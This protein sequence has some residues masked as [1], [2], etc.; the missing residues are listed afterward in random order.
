MAEPAYPSLEQEGKIGFEGIADQKSGGGGE[1]EGSFSVQFT[2]SAGE[3][4]KQQLNDDPQTSYRTFEGGEPGA[5]QASSED[6]V[7]LEKGTTTQ[8]EKEKRHKEETVL[9]DDDVRRIDFILTYQDDVS[10]KGKKADEDTDEKK[11]KRRAKRKQFLDSCVELGLEYEIQD[12]RET[13]DH[14]TYFVKV[15][16]TYPALLRGAEELLLR[17]PIRENNLRVQTYRERFFDLIKLRDPT[18][19][20]IPKHLQMQTYF[21]APFKLAHQE[22]YIGVDDEENFFTNAQRSTITWHL[23]QDAKYGKDEDQVGVL[24]LMQN[25]CFNGYYPL[26]ESSQKHTPEEG[27]QTDRQLLHNQWSYWT[28]WYKQQPLGHIR[29]YFGEKVGI[30]F[31]WIG[32]YTTWLLPVSLLGI[33][34]FLYGLSTIPLGRNAVAYDTC[35]T[36]RSQFYMCPVCDEKCD[37]WYLGDTC[38]FAH[39]NQLFDNGGTVFFAVIMSFWA[40]L[41]LEFWK[42]RQFYLQYDWDMLGY[43]SAEERARPEFEQRIKRYIRKCKDDNARQK[44]FVYNPVLEKKEYIQPAHWFWPKVIATFSILISMVGV[45]IA[46]VFSVLLYRLAVAGAIYRIVSGISGGPSIGDILVSITGAM[47]QLVAIIIMNKLYEFLAY[48]LTNWELHRTQTEYDDSF[49]TKMYLF[50]FVNFY[51]SLFYIAF[52]KGN[53]T[54]HPGG[55]NRVSGL[56]L[57]ECSTY[58]CM[59]ELTIQL[60]IIFVGKQILNNITELGVPYVKRLIKIFK[61]KEEQEEDVYTRWEKDF[62]L[63]P[64]SVHGLFYEYLELVIQ[65]GFVTV[66]VAAFPLAPLFALLNNWV[67][68]RLDAHKYVNVLRRPIS[69][70]AQD[71]GAWYSILAIVSQLAVVT[72]AILIAITSNFVGFEVYIRGGYD[73]EYNSTGIVPGGDS[74]ADQGLSGYANWSTTVY[75]VDELVDGEAFPAFT[76]QSLE[77][78]NDDGSEIT[79]DS[80]TPLYLPYINFECLKNST[81]CNGIPITTINVTKYGDSQIEAETFLEDDFETF[82]K[83]KSCRNLVFPGLRRT[84]ASPEKRGECFNEQFPCRFRGIVKDE[85]EVS[86]YHTW[87][88]RLAFIIMFEHFIF[89]ISGVLAWLIP[90]VPQSV[91]NEIQKEKLLAFEAIH[92][93]HDAGKELGVK[94]GETP[95]TPA[96]S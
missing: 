62:D 85:R 19:P 53:L 83:N 88:A 35:E 39:V 75:P 55:F 70:R 24:R 54:G 57:D 47:L 71:I 94:H 96:S 26:H 51:S 92:A 76:A 11:E 12:C 29:R 84:N 40:V 31:T 46:V 73:N 78:V 63:V 20:E 6:I 10:K 38:N 72:N 27:V 8:S 77:Y 50:Q 14:K 56:R 22:N 68:I 44:F 66:F 89:I 33:V 79:V 2:P 95:A 60:G 82:Y 41:F 59:L 43:E 3:A 90:D 17:M 61:H 34:I 58:G 23:L 28:N 37:F 5:M 21:T 16:A 42:R 9:F 69:E 80:Q 52:F 18:L 87:V 25:N 48:K 1:R 67:E 4:A 64:N 13:P 45:V 74:R 91:K 93:R 15:H 86:F 30:Y 36:A 65:Y 7:L 32:F 49:I 81:N